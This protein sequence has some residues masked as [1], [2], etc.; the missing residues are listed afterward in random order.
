[1]NSQSWCAADKGGVAVKSFLSLEFSASDETESRDQVGRYFKYLASA[2]GS[3]RTRVARR[4]GIW[5]RGSRLRHCAVSDRKGGRTSVLEEFDG[6]EEDL[7]VGCGLWVGGW[8]GW[9]R[10]GRVQDLMGESKA[11]AK[12]EAK[13]A[14]SSLALV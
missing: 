7:V 10:V 13:F 3:R 1:M 9:G 2:E 11:E 5:L 6:G 4:W 8:C 14:L 12:L